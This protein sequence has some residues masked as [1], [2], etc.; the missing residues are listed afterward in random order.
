MFKINKLLPVILSLILP[1]LNI[2][3]NNSLTSRVEVFYFIVKWLIVSLYLLFIWHLNK[4]IIS[5]EFNYDKIFLS[6]VLANGLAIMSFIFFQSYV[7]PSVIAYSDLS[8]IGLLAFRLTMASCVYITVIEASQAGK[9]RALLKLKNLSLQSENIKAQFEQLQQQVNPHFLFNS[10]GTLRSMVRSKD[11]QSEEYILKLAD[12]YRQ[13]LQK[14]D[15][16]TISLKEELSFF[17]SYIYLMKVRHEDAL[18]I[19]I[20]IDDKYLKYHLPVFALQL[21]TE[22]CIKHNVAS[23]RNPLILEIYVSDDDM[24]TVKNN[25]KPKRNLEESSGIGLKNLRRRYELMGVP[26]G[27]KIK[28]QNDFFITTIK[29]IQYEYLTN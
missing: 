23:V 1:G 9:D 2:L 8:S 15:S 19:N 29:L 26:E 5:L 10:L 16:N 6:L 22:N 12:V 21:L 3:N 27:L 4:K 7:F 24:L 25:F 11:V 17:E 18:S 28:E 13:I 20:I 14:R